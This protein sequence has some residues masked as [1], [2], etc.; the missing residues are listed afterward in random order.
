MTVT[1]RCT[2]AMGLI[3]GIV[4][5]LGTGR[6]VLAEALTI[7]ASHSLKPA[8][9]EIVPMFEQEYGV[10][11]EMVYGP[12]HTLRHHIEQGAPIDVFLPESLEDIE[13]LE[14]K[15]LTIHGKPRI[16]AAS[17]LVLVMSAASLATPISFQEALPNRG[18]RVA[19]VN[20]KTSAVGAV[21]ARVLHKINPA[22]KA[23]SN[24]V[25][26]E[27]TEDVVNFVDSGKADAGIVHRVDAIGNGRLRIIDEAP[28]GK[29][30]SVQFGEAIVSTCREASLEAA[31]E[32][33]DFMMSPRIQMLLLKY[34]FDTTPSD[35]RS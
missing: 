4:G 29:Q 27:H 6:P 31:Q 14:K 28:F 18:T 32:F 21:T 5:L 22:F 12:S 30:T 15:A 16:Y 3:G 20:P 24:F 13:K 9:H 10:T 2:L 33:V 34:G 17:S 25:F 7:A 1:L 35:R 19:L 8:F 11:V 23:G 26:G